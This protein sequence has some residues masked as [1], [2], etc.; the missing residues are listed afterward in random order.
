ML[1][2]TK[3]LFILMVLVLVFVVSAGSVFGVVCGETGGPTT[4]GTY[5]AQY[6]YYTGQDDCPAGCGSCTPT[7]TCTPTPC[8]P[9][10]DQATCND[11]TGTYDSCAFNWESGDWWTCAAAGAAC[12]TPLTNEEIY[13]HLKDMGDILTCGTG[14]CDADQLGL[15]EAAIKD[16]IPGFEGSLDILAGGDNVLKYDPATG[17]LSNTMPGPPPSTQSIKLSN[18]KNIGTNG[19]IEALANG[20]FRIT[21]DPSCTDCSVDDPNWGI[22]S[23]TGSITIGPEGQVIMGP[24]TN[25]AFDHVS[26]VMGIGGTFWPD[27]DFMT[28]GKGVCKD[29]K[30]A[31]FHIG[32]KEGTEWHLAYVYVDKE[33]ADVYVNKNLPHDKTGVGINGANVNGFGVEARGTS[34]AVVQALLRDVVMQIEV[35][36]Y[37]KYVGRD[38]NNDNADYS[39]GKAYFK[40]IEEGDKVQMTNDRERMVLA[41]RTGGKLDIKGCDLVDCGSDNFKKLFDTHEGLINKHFT[42]YSTD[43]YLYDDKGELVGILAKDKFF[44]AKGGS[45]GIFP[46]AGECTTDE[47]CKIQETEDTLCWCEFTETVA[48]TGHAGC[49]A[50]GAYKIISTGNCACKEKGILKCPPEDCHS[51]GEKTCDAKDPT[52]TKVC[53]KYTHME[54][55]AGQPIEC[56]RWK[57][58]PCPGGQCCKEGVCAASNCKKNCTTNAD[59]GTGECCKNG[60]CTSTGCAECTTATGCDDKDSCNGTT[61]VDYYCAVTGKCLFIEIPNH[62]AKCPECVDDTVCNIKDV[63]DGQNYIDYSCDTTKGKCVSITTEKS[64]N[65]PECL[66][67]S[68]CPADKCIN[69]THYRD[70]SCKDGFCSYVDSLNRDLCSECQSDGDCNEKD[71]CLANSYRDWSCDLGLGKCAYTETERP[72]KCYASKIVLTI[73][74]IYGENASGNLKRGE[75]IAKIALADGR[76]ISSIYKFDVYAGNDILLDSSGVTSPDNGFTYSGK[77]DLSILS[78]DTSHTINFNIVVIDEHNFQANVQESRTVEKIEY[79]Q[80]P[81][82]VVE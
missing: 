28:T 36:G 16:Q 69:K 80:N 10:Y 7:A 24:G 11:Y 44:C 46:G 67:D 22:F 18:Y 38:A 71:Q 21:F 3:K 68:E 79:L 43:I 54:G 72:P 45:T 27:S 47:V 32:Y 30:D 75:F 66:V 31:I 52:K 20:G 77:F 48:T 6:T 23:G 60:V 64:S 55:P 49:D 65:C 4:C 12:A 5:G 26:I 51:E 76:K 1:L 35:K 57:D 73:E 78:T 33:G 59:C 25:W 50:L 13:D 39:K 62:P 8:G 15:I 37:F 61:W 17:L 58:V 2:L 42:D 9:C 34:P 82:V 56:F 81:S 14:P 41:T 74:D 19:K 63:C 53:E 70:Y 29:C 40:G